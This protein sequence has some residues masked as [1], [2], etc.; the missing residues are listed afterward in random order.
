LEQAV[1]GAAVHEHHAPVHQ[2]L[3]GVRVRERHVGGELVGGG[4]DPPALQ[5]DEKDY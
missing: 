4:L 5:Q 1:S 3:R 2:L